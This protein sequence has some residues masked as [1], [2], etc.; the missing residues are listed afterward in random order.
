M[1]ASDQLR[2]I[3]V[4]G[5]IAGFA[6]AIALR[7]PNRR[8]T[9][10]E[11]SRLNHEIGALISLQPNA[12]QILQKTW[13]LD[14]E[15]EQARGLV[16]EG[17]RIYDVDGKLVNEVPLLSKTEY[18]GDRIVWH[19]NDLHNALKAAAR[20]P[21]RRGDPA[22]IRVAS[23]VVNCDPHEGN[24]TLETG[25]ILTADVI[26]G[27][28]GIVLRECVLID[29]P[30]PMPTGTSAY[31]LMIPSAVLEEEE[32]QFCSRIN[33]RHS[34]TSMIVAHNC[35]LVMGPGR[36]GDV[37]AVTALV[38]DERMNEDSG[39]S[40]VSEGSLVKMLET[41]AEFPDWVTSIFKHSPDIGLWQLRDMDPLKT[42]IRGRVILIG[43]AA[44]PMLP[45]QGQGA[46]QAI[47]DAEALGAFFEDVGEALSVRQLDHIF[48]VIQ[49]YPAIFCCRYG[50]VSLIQ[51][52][53]RQAAKPGT[54][55]D[56]K[57]VT[58]ATQYGNVIEYVGNGSQRLLTSWLDAPS[59]ANLRAL[60]SESRGCYS[61]Y[62]GSSSASY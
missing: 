53:S 55:K 21:N 34:Y 38:P 45:T 58:M 16:D 9:V 24:V 33:P 1:P 3:I 15:L 14:K 30:A 42:W 4:G 10:L 40:W 5:G 60:L 49:T 27:A 13:G 47:E 7:A 35:R 28:D 31:R 32:P 62:G 17:F 26:I 57:T 48:N 54:V 8:I 43:D 56:E 29:E 2:I 61:S 51:Q 6:A 20:C 44:H 46:S 36:Q 18:G 52:G 41:F 39:Q 50:R 12:S 11:Q 19:R 25:E 23:R 59:H 37:Y 22:T